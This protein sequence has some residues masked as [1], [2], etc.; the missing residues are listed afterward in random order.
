MAEVRKTENVTVCVTDKKAIYVNKTRITHRGTKW[1]VHHTLEEFECAK[2]DV[3][4]EVGRRGYSAWV[5][6]I[7]DPEYQKSAKQ[8]A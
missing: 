4:S 8:G 1:G 2:A 3:V 7:D 6:N 5:K